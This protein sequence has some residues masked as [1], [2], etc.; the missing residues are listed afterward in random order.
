M[1]VSADSYLAGE[2]TTRCKHEYLDGRIYPLANGGEHHDQIASNWL[3]LIRDQLSGSQSNVFDSNT[4]IRIRLPTETRFY[5]SDGMVV[6]QA[7]DDVDSF[8]DRP[9]VVAE[10]VTHTTRRFD[11]IEKREAYLAIPSL[12]AYMLIEVDRPRVVVHRRSE[13]GFVG[14]AYEGLPATIS[15]DA[16][17]VELLLADL[18]ERVDFAP[19]PDDEEPA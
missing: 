7:T 13:P 9:V 2:L 15:L 17:G 4:R 11:E 1:S 19:E 18:Y 8:Q 5:Y 12:M 10:V 14:E 16:I 3:N 6:C